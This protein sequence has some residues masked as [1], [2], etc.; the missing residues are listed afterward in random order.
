MK[1]TVVLTATVLFAFICFVYISSSLDIQSAR[2]EAASHLS[3]RGE[4][5]DQY[6]MKISYHLENKLLGYSPYRI[7]VVYLDEPG[8]NYFYD[9]DSATTAIFQSGIAPLEGAADRKDFKHAN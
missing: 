4:S 1:K 5:P 9:Y 7:K 8:V 6:E 2:R 3:A